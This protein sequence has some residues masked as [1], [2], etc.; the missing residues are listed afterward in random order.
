MTVQH[1]TH[2][3]INMDVFVS[4]KGHIVFTCYETLSKRIERVE[5]EKSSGE[6]TFIFQ[7][8]MEEWR[9]NCALSVELCDKVENQIFCAIGYFRN[10]KMIAGEYVNFLCR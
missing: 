4:P 8:D 5:L 1:N 10:K 2:D 9:P 7:P 3:K 6:I